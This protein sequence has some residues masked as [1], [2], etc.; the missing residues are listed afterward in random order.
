MV[1]IGTKGFGDEQ[2]RI[3]A[4]RSKV[5][6]GEVDRVVRKGAGAIGKAMRAVRGKSR[7]EKQEANRNKTATPNQSPHLF[8]CPMVGNQKTEAG[9]GH[10]APPLHRSPATPK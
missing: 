4:D 9:R 5:G 10:T 7:R 2:G 6:M 8:Y 1:L 3:T